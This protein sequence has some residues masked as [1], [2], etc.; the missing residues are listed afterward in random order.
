MVQKQ[1]KQITFKIFE[2][3][4]LTAL[5]IKELAL[6]VV[7]YFTKLAKGIEVLEEYN[8]TYQGKK[9]GDIMEKLM[10]WVRK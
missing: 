4:P 9:M 10:G 3:Y 6:N 7:E 8:D 5:E 2:D 1:N